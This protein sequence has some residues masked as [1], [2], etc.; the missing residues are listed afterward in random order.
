[1]LVDKETKKFNLTLIL[2]CKVPWNFSKKEEYD[3]IIRNWQIMFQASN[4]KKNHFLEL[5]DNNYHTITSTYTKGGPW[6]NH[7]SHLN[8]LCTR[9]TRA[10]TNYTPIE[11]YHLRFFL[12]EDFSCLYRSYSI[13]S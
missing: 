3:N 2:P 5:L 6:I 7:F 9:A 11:E 13:E 10:I 4:L 12:K 1:M 8:S